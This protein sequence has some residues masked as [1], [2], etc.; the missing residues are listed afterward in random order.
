MVKFK[1]VSIKD[2]K[3]NFKGKVKFGGYIPWH[4]RGLENLNTRNGD[5]VTVNRNRYWRI[6]R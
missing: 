5:V 6:K 2:F 4:T 1:R 3:E